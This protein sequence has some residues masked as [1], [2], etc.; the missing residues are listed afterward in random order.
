MDRIPF[1]VHCLA[2]HNPFL[3]ADRNSNWAADHSPVVLVVDHNPALADYSLKTAVLNIHFENFELDSIEADCTV[4]SVEKAA[5]PSIDMFDTLS[6]ASTTHTS[7]QL[8]K[9]AMAKY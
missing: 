1:E 2:N 7:N 8:L 9:L 5:V 4:K 6:A 3:A